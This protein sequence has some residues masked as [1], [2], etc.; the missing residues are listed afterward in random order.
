MGE[1]STGQARDESLACF[2][3]LVAAVIPMTCVGHRFWAAEEEVDR[4]R[5]QIHFLRNLGPPG[6]PPPSCTS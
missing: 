6:G 3:G 2:A 5:Q 1:T 4:R